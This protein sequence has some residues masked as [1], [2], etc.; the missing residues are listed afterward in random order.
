MPKE[1]RMDN[2]SWFAGLWASGVTWTGA[3]LTTPP[4]ASVWLWVVGLIVT[5]LFGVA[6]SAVTVLLKHWLSERKEAKR[7]KTAERGVKA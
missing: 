5:G 3:I 6:S 7:L 1:K 4:D 2:D